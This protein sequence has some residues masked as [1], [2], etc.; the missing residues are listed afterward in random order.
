[1]AVM[2]PRARQAF[3]DVPPEV[4]TIGGAVADPDSLNPVLRRLSEDIPPGTV[5]GGLQRSAAFPEEARTIP[6]FLGDSQDDAPSFPRFTEPS[7]TPD[8]GALETSQ[9]EALGRGLQSSEA[10]ALGTLNRLGLIGS[11]A[12]LATRTQAGALR[13]AGEAD[14]EQRIAMART[15]FATLDSQRRN[16]WNAAKAQYDAGNWQFA[17]S[18]LAQYEAMNA[19]LQ[20]RLAESESGGFSFGG[21][22]GGVAGAFGGP[23]L[24]TGGAAVG[25]RI[26]G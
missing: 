2:N 17:Q 7:F 5:I 19:E 8:F 13:G 9:K 26:F 24:A 23:L 16:A 22:L 18:L 11:G 25:K 14:I 12:E 4:E 10:Q 3:E 6:G 15:D 21:L 1:M 20:S